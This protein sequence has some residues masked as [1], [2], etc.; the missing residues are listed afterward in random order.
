MAQFAHFLQ[1]TEFHAFAVGLTSPTTGKAHSRWLTFILS[2]DGVG[3]SHGTKQAY[4]PFHHSAHF[5]AMWEK[6]TKNIHV[7]K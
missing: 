5:R 3:Q 1:R 6:E 2:H 4:K 7:R